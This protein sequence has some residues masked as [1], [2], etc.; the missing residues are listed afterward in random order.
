M[1][2]FGWS[3]PPGA[4]GD[5]FAPYNQT[6]EPLDLREGKTLKGYGRTDH[7]LNGKDAD[8][9]EGGQNV[10]REAYWFDSDTIHIVGSRYASICGSEDW[11]E[12]Q[13]EIA[14]EI[15]CDAPEPGEWDGDYWVLT[16]DYELHVTCPW[17]DDE[18]EEEN[19]KRAC[20]A[21]HDAICEDSKAFEESM[22]ALSKAMNSIGEDNDDESHD[23]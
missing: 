18:T 5:P 11:T 13:W 17:S 2:I 20:A 14:T 4:A 22:S 16:Q 21:A 8:L 6:D 12:A 7:G 19:I 3:Y 15:V 9:D 1:S 23:Q 10:V